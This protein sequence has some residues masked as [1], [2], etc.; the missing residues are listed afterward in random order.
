MSLCIKEVWK[1]IYS[2]VSKTFTLQHIYS[3]MMHW[4]PLYKGVEIGKTK[5]L[6]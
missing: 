1:I 4:L 2:E 5:L 6:R 3:E